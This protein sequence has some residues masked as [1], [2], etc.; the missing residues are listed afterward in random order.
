MKK[1]I[2]IIL[3][4][5]SSISFGQKVNINPQITQTIQATWSISSLFFLPKIKDPLTKEIVSKAIPKL[6]AQDIK[7]SVYEITDAFYRIK[8]IKV[9]NKEFLMQIEK[10]ITIGVKAVQQSDYATAV[11]ELA[12]TV[13]LAD[14]YIKTGILEKEEQQV[15]ISE[16]TQNAAKKD[17]FTKSDVDS[18]LHL[19]EN[20]NYLFFMTNGKFEKQNSGELKQDGNST[21]DNFAVTFDDGKK[22][23]FGVTNFSASISGDGLKGEIER[24]LKTDLGEGQIT[25][26]TSGTF[27]HFKTLKYSYIINST[28]EMADV[29][30]YQGSRNIM[31]YFHSSFEN[32]KEASKLFEDLMNTFFILDN[33][34]NESLTNSKIKS[35]DS[36]E[37]INTNKKEI[38]TTTKSYSRVEIT[39]IT[40]NQIPAKMTS[41]LP[42]DPLGGYP[43]IYYTIPSNNG[44]LG[45]SQN[46]LIDCNPSS[47]PKSFFLNGNSFSANEAISI[48]LY[49]YDIGSSDKIGAVSF[50][51]NQYTT[52][53]NAF[54]PQITQANNGTSLTISVKWNE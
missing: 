29:H 7:G 44:Q 9:L 50:N 51:L 27:S 3:I 26:S 19:G 11:N 20:N 38:T 40:I 46:Q 18:K 4:L 2:I 8:N 28:S 30:V 45:S 14:A 39:K 10:N 52:G 34:E 54:P 25:S 48:T 1:S 22:L 15:S 41:Y 49:D 36:N 42:W 12:R 5:T 35:Q 43:D 33:N 37:S 32:Y 6:I 17:I 53:N 24:Q 23:N 13:V 31:I 21:K 16:E 47:M